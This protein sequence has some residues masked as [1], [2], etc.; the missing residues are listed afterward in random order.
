MTLTHSR[1]VV[2]RLL[3]LKFTIDWPLALCLV[4][5]DIS[6]M[7]LAP[8]NILDRHCHHPILQRGTLRLPAHEPIARDHRLLSIRNRINSDDQGQGVGVPDS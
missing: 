7:L 2:S 4:L 6:V 5:S 3:S 1:G 8:R